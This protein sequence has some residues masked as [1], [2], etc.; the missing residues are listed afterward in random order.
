[1]KFRPEDAHHATRK[2]DHNRT[3]R[4]QWANVANSA[5]AAG[6]PAGV[7]ITMANGV[8]AKRVK[9]IQ[10]A[11]GRVHRANPKPKSQESSKLK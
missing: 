9:G 5:K 7:A 4:K 10:E 3:L 2:V 1:M 11:G 8:I 6:R